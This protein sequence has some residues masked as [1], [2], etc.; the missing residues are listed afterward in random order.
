[1]FFNIFWGVLNLF[2]IWPLDGGRVARELFI[3]YD[4]WRGVARS[5]VLSMVA[6]GIIIFLSLNNQY[7]FVPELR[8]L[9]WFWPGTLFSAILFGLVLYQNYQEYQ[10]LKS[11]GGYD[12]RP[13]WR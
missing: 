12:D 10:A 7:N 3:K 1:M 6:A 4:P 9:L 5:L 2:P 11:Y 13:P 8:R